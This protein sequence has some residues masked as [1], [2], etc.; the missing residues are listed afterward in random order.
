MLAMTNRYVWLRDP[1]FWLG[2]PLIIGISVLSVWL[3]LARDR[4]D[5]RPPVP[6]PPARLVATTPALWAVTDTIPASGT[7]VTC[8]VTNR[9]GIDCLID[10]ALEGAQ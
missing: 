5:S 6:Q 4:N 1:G 3:A 8:Y 9:G 7:I 2:W 10:P